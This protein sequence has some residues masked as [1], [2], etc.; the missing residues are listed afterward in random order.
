MI[1]YSAVNYY[2]KKLSRLKLVV[3]MLAQPQRRDVRSS[4]LSQNIT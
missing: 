3:V 1:I 2:V 4:D